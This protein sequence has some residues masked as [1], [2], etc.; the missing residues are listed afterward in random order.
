MQAP[1]P[2]EL[3][4]FSYDEL[5]QRFRQHALVEAPRPPMRWFDAI[6]CAAIAGALW[7]LILS[8]AF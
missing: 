8:A 7:Y 3:P 1:K 5:P 2:V 4:P 6:A